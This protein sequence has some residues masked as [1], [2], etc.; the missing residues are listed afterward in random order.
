MNE[1]EKSR[2]IAVVVLGMHRSG[3]SALSRILGFLGC[4]MPENLLGAGPGNETGHWEPATVLAVNERILASAGSY[5]HDWVAIPKEWAESPKFPVFLDEAAAALR[6]DFKNSH[7]FAI[8]DPRICRLFPF[9]R[10]VLQAEG[11]T[12]VV[13]CPIRSPIEVAESLSKRDGFHVSWGHVLWLRNVLEAERDSRGVPRYF[14][15]YDQLLDN[16]AK[17]AADSQ[18]ALGLKW[19]V[20]LDSADLNV[21]RF[22]QKSQRH[23]VTNPANVLENPVLSPWLKDVYRIMLR[24]AESGEKEADWPVLDRVRAE[25]ALAEPAF[26]R[27]VAAG[28]GLVQWSRRLEKSNEQLK[29]HDSALSE[30]ARL[31][32]LVKQAE[33]RLAGRFEEIVK[34]TEI[35]QRAEGDLQ[36][37]GTERDNRTVEAVVGWNGWPLMPDRIRS[38]LKHAFLAR[39]GLFDDNFYREAYPD[40]AAAGLDPL[41][42]FVRFGAR[43]GRHWSRAAA[44][45]AAEKAA[46][47]DTRVRGLQ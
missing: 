41:T 39:T 24:W 47:A 28:W 6:A 33:E 32:V 3:T 25:M 42:H 16:W 1:A 45:M 20:S 30:I 31:T 29:D 15:T 43:E 35:V 22:L 14:A 19:P 37:Q 18:A 44:K 38:R 4:D 46:L 23:H 27:A 34:L 17:V 9:W 12:P 5:S 2:R 13:I 10:T 7:L 26:G 40:V 11:V 8:K 21:Q 36:V